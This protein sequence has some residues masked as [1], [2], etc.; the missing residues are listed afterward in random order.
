M[1]LHP[2][3][4]VEDGQIPMMAKWHHGEMLQTWKK[5]RKRVLAVDPEAREAKVDEEAAVVVD[6]PAKAMTTICRSDSL[7]KTM[8]RA[9]RAE[10]VVPWVASWVAPWEAQ[11]VVPWVD[12]WE[13]PWE[14]PWVVPWVARVENRVKSARRAKAAVEGVGA[15]KVSQFQ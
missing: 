12:P 5:H 2:A 11:W 3:V 13:D 7:A 6:V 10:K 8:E 15:I 1:D 14:D 9:S 4:P